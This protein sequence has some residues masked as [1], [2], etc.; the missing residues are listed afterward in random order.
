[1]ES[2][3]IPGRLP[4]MND[5]FQAARASARN[6]KQNPEARLRKKYEDMIIIYARRGL[7]H[8]RARSRIILHYTFYEANRRRDMDNVSGYAH[9]LIQDS[10]VKGGFLHNDNWDV[11]AGYTDTFAVDKARP[12]IV[13]K[14]E[15]VE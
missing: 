7:K 13:V 5:A 3:T 12:R 1:M 4:G 2:F 8:W 9:K 14:I 10:L 11:I 6:P 15:E